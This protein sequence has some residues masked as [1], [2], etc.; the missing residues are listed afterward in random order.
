LEYDISFD[1]A[2][3]LVTVRAS[4]EATLE[5]FL[6]YAAE[7]L[8]LPGWR[9]GTRILDDFRELDLGAL[10][11]T[12]IR[13]IADFHIEHSSEIGRGQAA[14]VTGG[15]VAF[16]MARMWQ[17]FAQRGLSLETRVFS[18]MDLASSWLAESRPRAA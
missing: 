2:A 6:A 15:P 1:E 10:S 9:P 8:A 18:S 4:G 5:G 13:S 12:E 7:I 11:A 14:I 17:A 3:S 16:G